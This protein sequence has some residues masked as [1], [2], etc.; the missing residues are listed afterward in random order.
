MP[1]LEIKMY[2][3]FEE[4][5]FENGSDVEKIIKRFFSKYPEIV[6]DK[7]YITYLIKKLV[8]SDRTYLIVNTN[9]NTNNS[10]VKQS[11]VEHN[12]I[13]EKNNGKHRYI[14]SINSFI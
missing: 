1:Y 6:G 4:L 11:F 13:P 12:V 14:Y 9:N 7:E 3:D 2:Y 5:F 10:I 8:T